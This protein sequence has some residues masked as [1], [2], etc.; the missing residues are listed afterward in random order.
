M[1]VS[2]PINEMTRQELMRYLAEHPGE[3]QEGGEVFEEL[4][5]RPPSPE[6][7][8]LAAQFNEWL[9]N[10]GGNGLVTDGL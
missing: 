9:Q 1:Q 8:A 6:E 3:C 2:K 7:V 5:R 4:L 10:T